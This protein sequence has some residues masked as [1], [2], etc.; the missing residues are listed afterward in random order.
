MNETGGSQE[1][2]A[3]GTK[4]MLL[5]DILKALICIQE[6]WTTKIQIK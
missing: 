5:D 1:G 3:V 4:E 2:C 6:E